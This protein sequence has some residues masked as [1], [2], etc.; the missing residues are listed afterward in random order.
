M[1]NPPEAHGATATSK[2]G[3]WNCGTCEDW[4]TVVND[5]GTVVTPCPA[6]QPDAYEEWRLDTVNGRPEPSHWLRQR[7]GDTETVRLNG[8][9]AEMIAQRPGAH[10]DHLNAA[11]VVWR[12]PD[13]DCVGGY[14]YYTL[15]PVYEKPK[16]AAQ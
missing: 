11:G 10:G 1:Q 8:A 15:T 5:A 6:C 16:A 2:H 3:K 12:E 13:D 9:E 14:A 4:R 7:A